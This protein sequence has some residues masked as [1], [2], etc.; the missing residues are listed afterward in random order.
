LLEV[1]VDDLLQAGGAGLLGA[2]D[3]ESRS[4]FDSEAAPRDQVLLKGGL[5]SL[6]FQAFGCADGGFARRPSKI[7]TLD[8]EN[9]GSHRDEL[10]Q[11]ILVKPCRACK[12]SASE[13]GLDNCPSPARA[14]SEQIVGTMELQLR[15]VLAIRP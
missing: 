8:G 11:H 3:K 4:L 1:I 10:G 15:E 14:P 7:M 5:R 2:L 6:G 9:G 13:S 12:L